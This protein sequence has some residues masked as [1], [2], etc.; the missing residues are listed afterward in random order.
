MPTYDYICMKCGRDLEDQFQ[1]ITDK[2]LS[3]CPSCK[4]EA[5][6]RRPGGGIGVSFTGSGFYATDYRRNNKTT[7][8][9]AE[10]KSEGCCPCGQQKSSCSS[11]DAGSSVK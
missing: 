3:Q 11:E 9:T 7:E 10:N 6:Q 8:S 1:K 2:P 5:L 4:E